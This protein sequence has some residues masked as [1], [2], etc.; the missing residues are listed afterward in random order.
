MSDWTPARSASDRIPGTIAGDPVELLVLR[1]GSESRHHVRIGGRELQVRPDKT[2]T[3]AHRS[4][5]LIDALAELAAGT[6]DP[7]TY[8][9]GRLAEIGATEVD[10][11]RITEGSD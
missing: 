4:R 10:V 2:T 9:Q 3:G 1:S 11:I 6:V 8:L 7:M 5:V